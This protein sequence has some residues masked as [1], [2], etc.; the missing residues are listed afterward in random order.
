MKRVLIYYAHPGHRTSRVNRPMAQAAERIADIDFVDLY[1]TYPR[2]NIDVSAEQERILSADIIIFQF[3]VFWY[4][5]PSII[6]DWQDLVLQHGFAY[7]AGGDRLSGKVMM[8]AVTAAGPEEAYAPNGY[9]HYPLRTFLTPLEQTARLCRMHFTAP[10]V[11]YSSLKA[12]EEDRVGQHVEGYV[13]LIEALRDERY[14]FP[15]AD[16]VDVVNYATLPIRGES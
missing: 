13:R 6:K 9:Q 8:L 15:A 14:D 12:P 11:L 1:Y 4:S 10:Y 3:P 5:T 16:T 2:H 7:G